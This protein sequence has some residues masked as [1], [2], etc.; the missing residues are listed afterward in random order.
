MPVRKI[1]KNYRNVTGIAAHSKSVGSA[2][3]EST[4]ERDFLSLVE[5]SKDVTKFEVQ[6]VSIEW[7]D[8]SGKRHTYVPD[9]LVH[10]KQSRHTKVVILYEVKYRSDLKENWQILKPKFKAAIAYCKTRCWRF[11]LVTEVEIRTLIW[12]TF[13]FCNLM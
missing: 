4:L 1:P 7:F 6:P 11:K 5:F 3:F 13:G 2:A 12:I 9:V 10:Y 8:T